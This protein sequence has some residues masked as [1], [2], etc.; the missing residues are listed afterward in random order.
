M[1]PEIC[2]PPPEQSS[3]ESDVWS[4]GCI[5]L[6]TTSSSEPWMTQFNDDAVLF[7][8]LQRKDNAPLFARV[9]ANESGP[10]HICKLLVRCC[11][12]SKADR[13]RFVD[14][15]NLLKVAHDS[16]QFTDD[17]DDQMS[18]D[19]SFSDDRPCSKEDQN[20][21][22]DHYTSDEDETYRIH[23][24]PSPAQRF[25]DSPK[26]VF[27]KPNGRL[28]RLTGEVYTSTGSASGRP[29][30]EGVKGGRYYVTASGSKVYLQK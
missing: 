15:L 4:Y 30:Y 29:I 5:I 24:R 22:H 2:S 21:G 1:A 13:P 17:T 26:Q 11:T 27:S 10:S 25:I 28:G 14:I 23:N 19:A 7:R 9:C 12:W 18:I 8:A 20:E 16:D 6:E 3:R